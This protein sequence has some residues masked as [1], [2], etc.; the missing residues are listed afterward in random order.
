LPASVDA[1]EFEDSP[2]T[3][4]ATESRRAIHV[5]CCIKDD[6]CGRR[7]AIVTARKA[8]KNDFAPNS[9]GIGEFKDSAFAVGAAVSR[10]AIQ[11]AGR[12]G[13][14]S[15]YRIATVRASTKAVQYLFVACECAAS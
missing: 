15:G 3:I 13:H 4:R 14:H 10:G 12:I 2:G 6:G 8:V 1:G 5:A 7:R 11:I 9:V